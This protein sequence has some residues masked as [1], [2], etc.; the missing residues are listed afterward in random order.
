[1]DN[2]VGTHRDGLVLVTGP[3]CGGKSRWAERLVMK[4]KSVCY[5]AT[6]IPQECDISMQKRIQIHRDRRP[7]HWRL[8]ESEGKLWED[9]LLCS[10][11]DVILI[12]S[13][14]GFVTTHLDLPSNEWNAYEELLFESIKNY[15]GKLILVVEEVGWGVVPSSRIGNIFKD[16]V[17]LLSQRL[18]L[19]STSSW[20]VLQ[21]RALN[22]KKLGVSI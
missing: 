18:E 3:S 15:G 10:E 9:I 14:G 12:D 20:L 5:I 6:T 4:S 21:G 11:L 17:G 7:A 19:L 13:L 2:D 16:R 8:I 1:M 22:L